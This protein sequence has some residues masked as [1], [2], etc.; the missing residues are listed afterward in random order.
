MPESHN[1]SL[2][3]ATVNYHSISF[4]DRDDQTTNA[5]G[6]AAFCCGSLS[7]QITSEQLKRN[8][9]IHITSSSDSSRF[10]VPSGTVDEFPSLGNYN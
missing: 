8:L 2:V 5:S 9:R 4:H 7:I 10:C 3:C 6:E 1:R